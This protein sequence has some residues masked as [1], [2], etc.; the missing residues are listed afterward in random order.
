MRIMEEKACGTRESF[1]PTELQSKCLTPKAGDVGLQK[2]PPIVMTSEAQGYKSSLR[3]EK[4]GLCTSS[5]S[6]QPLLS[7]LSSES[8]QQPLSLQQ[9]HPIY[10][11]L[12]ADDGT[13]TQ[14][15]SLEREALRTRGRPWDAPGPK[16]ESLRQCYPILRMWHRMTRERKGLVVRRLDLRQFLVS[17]WLLLN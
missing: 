3:A 5:E 15:S 8:L 12:S 10:P 9:Q 6:L 17:T 2:D 13:A 1:G 14:L 4:L 16:R 11:P 7:V